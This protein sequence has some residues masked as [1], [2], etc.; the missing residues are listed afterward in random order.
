M[1]WRLVLEGKADFLIYSQQIHP[2]NHFLCF[3]PG[4]IIVNIIST[5]SSTISSS[6]FCFCSSKSSNF[7]P[8]DNL[9]Y[10]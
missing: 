3:S 10:L 6:R 8:P 4:I 7:D 5:T 1:V 2:V 9:Q